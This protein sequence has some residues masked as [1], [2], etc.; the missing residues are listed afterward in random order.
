M[1]SPEY[2]GY[3]AERN[4]EPEV[5]R[6]AKEILDILLYL[7]ESG[8]ELDPDYKKALRGK[9]AVLWD[10]LELDDQDYGQKVQVLSLIQQYRNGDIDYAEA[11]QY[12]GEIY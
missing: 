10:S 2:G 11:L 3:S 5:I 8:P 4:P 1:R 7:I 9:L 6:I 12:L